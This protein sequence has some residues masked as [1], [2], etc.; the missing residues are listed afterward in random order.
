MSLARTTRVVNATEIKFARNGAGSSAAR[1]FA[2]ALPRGGLPCID[3]IKNGFYRDRVAVA[4]NDDV[5]NVAELDA[6]AGWTLDCVRVSTTGTVFVCF[7]E[8][9][10]R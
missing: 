7:E 1:R 9:A 4:L 10:D 3:R 5:N 2:A 8:V 6:P